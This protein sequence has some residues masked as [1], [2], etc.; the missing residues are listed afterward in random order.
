MV[1][2]LIE[3]LIIDCFDVYGLLD[4]IED[5]DGD[6]V[7]LGRLVEKFLEEPKNLWHVERGAKPAIQRLRDVGNAAAHGRYRRTLRQSLDR[8]RESLE[9]AI[10]QLVGIIRRGEIKAR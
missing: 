3:I 5:S 4:E 7:G 2:R 10:Q 9:I 8:Y 6:I 1:R